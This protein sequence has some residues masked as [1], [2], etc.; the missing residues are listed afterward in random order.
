[1]S[2]RRGRRKRRLRG[3]HMARPILTAML[4]PCQGE[5]CLTA[6]LLQEQRAGWLLY[7]VLRSP[8]SNDNPL[9]SP[10]LDHGWRLGTRT[11]ARTWLLSL[12]FGRR[13]LFVQR[14]GAEHTRARTVRALVGDVG[15]ERLFA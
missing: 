1:M 4:L 9:M 15:I 14:P 13:R 11:K 2:A 8:K 6:R 7:L 10:K 12:D 3:I 5:P